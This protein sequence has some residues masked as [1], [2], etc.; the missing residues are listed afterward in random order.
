MKDWLIAHRGD[1]SRGQENTLEAFKAAKNSLADWIELDIHTTKDKVVICNH[2]F[3]IGDLDIDHCTFKR[4]KKANPKLT[5]FKDAVGVL[6]DK[7]LIIEIKPKATAKFVIDELKKHSNWR[8]A[9]FKTSVIQELIDLGFD[10]KRIYLLQHKNT[11]KQ[12]KKAKNLGVGGIGINQRWM[13]PRIY[14]R[15]F[16]KGLNV[17]T[18]TVNSKFQ[19]RLFRLLY[20]KLL[21]CSDNP[22]RFADIK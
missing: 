12:L 21:I 10:K 8:V 15:A 18:Y 9:S 5:T 11:Y 17:Y 14:R 2:D 7:K 13:T 1:Q 16:Y 22:E 3:K 4:L 6:R 19:A 20:P